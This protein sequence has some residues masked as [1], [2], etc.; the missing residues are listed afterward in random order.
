M[1]MKAAVI[2]LTSVR[3]Y[4]TQLQALATQAKLGEF[5]DE[6]EF[7]NYCR[8]DTYGKGLVSSYA[9]GNP[10]RGAA[11]LPTMAVW[12][13]KF[14]KFQRQYLHLTDKKY[15]TAEDFAQYKQDADIFFTGSDQ[16]WNAGWNDGIIPFLYLSFVR[17][18]KPKVAF[19]SSFGR[20]KLSPKEIASCKPYLDQF[21]EISIR[22]ES[23]KKILTDD[24]HYDN[25]TR[26]VDPLSLIHI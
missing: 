19:S 9:K 3:N 22:E 6:V 12:H 15:E 11:I 4:G 23:G 20:N 2:T 24:F 16:V 5:Y 18:D 21:K 10:I 25:V 14:G 7:I 1:S 26:L 13:Y 8:P 17:S